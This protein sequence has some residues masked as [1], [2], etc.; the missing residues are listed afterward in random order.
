MTRVQYPWQFSANAL[1]S[2]IRLVKVSKDPTPLR[3]NRGKKFEEEPA[4]DGLTAETG[5]D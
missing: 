1:N 5:F 3:N 4:A 2:G